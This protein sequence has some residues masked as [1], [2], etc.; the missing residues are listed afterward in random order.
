MLVIVLPGDENPGQSVGTYNSA[1]LARCHSGFVH[2]V[3]I[4]PDIRV[5][6]IHRSSICYIYRDIRVEWAVKGNFRLRHFPLHIKPSVVSCAIRC[7]SLVRRILIDRVD[8]AAHIEPVPVTGEPELTVARA[9][10]QNADNVTTICAILRA[11]FIVY[12]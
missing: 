4:V 7:H 12:G 5:P 6:D 8:N 10:L 9:L 2:S 3:A 1:P 11:V